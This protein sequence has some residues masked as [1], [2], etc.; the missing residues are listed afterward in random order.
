MA[1]VRDT[2]SIHLPRWRT[3]L[4]SMLLV[5]GLGVVVSPQVQLDVCGC[6]NNPASLGNFDTL[7]AATYPPGTTSVA[8]V[9]IENSSMANMM[10]IDAR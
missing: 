2:R 3:M 8:P 7:D 10:L 4:L 9:V 6:K 1:M 5:C